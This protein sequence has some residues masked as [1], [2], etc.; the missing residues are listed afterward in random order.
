MEPKEPMVYLT[1]Q[2]KDNVL[3][4]LNG[5]ICRICVS[6]DAHEVIRLIGCANRYLSDLGCD[7]I[8]RIREERAS[9]YLDDE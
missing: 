9:R 7:N 6:D 2:Q 3:R 5:C 1:R 4:M 8:R